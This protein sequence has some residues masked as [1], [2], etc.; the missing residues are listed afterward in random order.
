MATITEYR[1]IEGL[2]YAPIISDD[3]DGYVT[4]AVKPLVAV[5][6]I[7]KEVEQ[8]SETHY[9]DNIPAIV[10]QGQGADTITITS[11]VIPF[12]VLAEITGQTYIANKGAF[13]EGERVTKYF[14]IGY[15]TKK[16]NGKEVYVWRYKGTF[17][18][19]SDT[20]ATENDGTDANGQELTFTGISTNYKF[21][22]TGKHA[23]GLNVDLE[24]NLADVSTFFDEVTTPDTLTAKTD[25]SLT[26]TQAEGTTLKVLRNGVQLSSSDKVHAGDELVIICIGGTITVNSASF[27]NGGTYIVSE[28]TTVTSTASA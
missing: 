4:G 17:N 6:E 15:K 8:S 25:L 22:S 23:M 2:V 21:T 18:I 5:S 1:G 20:H 28:A 9:Y 7:S 11:A 10:L 19:P 24:K 13:I 3:K 27:E 16:T 26:V 14:A 12:D